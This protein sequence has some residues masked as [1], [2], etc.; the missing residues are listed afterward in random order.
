MVPDDLAFINIHHVGDVV[1]PF[2]PGHFVNA[3]IRGGGNGRK[4]LSGQFF[5]LLPIDPVDNLVVE[6]EI[7]SG[8]LVRGDRSKPVHLFGKS[9]GEPPPEPVK[10]LDP[11]AVVG[12]AERLAFRDVQE[13]SFAAYGKVLDDDHSYA[14]Y[15]CVVDATAASADGRSECG[16]F[17]QQI[18]AV[19]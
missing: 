9:L 7:P 19:I 14:V 4:L 1:M 11:D 15:R 6:T 17:Q 12:G 5:K 8:L 2:L 10:F 13:H 16:L 18:K 3:H